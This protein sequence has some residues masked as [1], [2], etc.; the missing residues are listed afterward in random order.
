MARARLEEH[1]GT[2]KGA[3]AITSGLEVTWTS[4]PTQWSN[5][6]FDNLFGHE[7]ELSKSPAGAH[8]WVAK[9]AEADRARRRDGG[10]TAPPDD[11]HHRPGLRIDP[12]YEQ[13]SRRFHE[14][15][16]EFRLAFAKAWYKL[17]HR[18]MGPVS[19]YLGPQ[20]AEPQLWQDPV[21][22][23]DDDAGLRRRRRR[24]QGQVLDFRAVRRPAGRVP[25]GPRRPASATPTSVAAPTAPASASR[26]R[27]TGRPTS[28][29]A[30]R[31]AHT[32]EKVRQEFNGAGGAQISLADLIVLAGSAAVEKA[33]KDAGHD[34]TVPFTPGAP[35]PPRSRPTSSRSPCSSRGPT[36]SATTCGPA[37]SCA[38]D[39]AGRPAYMLGLSAPEMTVLVGGLR[40][41]GANA[42]RLEHGVLTDRSG[43]LT[44]TS[45]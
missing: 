7:W 24:P 2:G 42:G 36:A 41:L 5:G 40:A 10:P 21:P 20:V 23:H 22:A 12:E 39:P 4:T 45:S 25:R 30:R 19:R 1:L 33:A 8:Q 28:R 38:R 34:V 18:D 26:P 14:D 3:D 6:F 32:L 16:D 37:R 43:T 44:T 31:R 35:T 11:A 17:L 15:P 9:D 13:I 27:R 29:P